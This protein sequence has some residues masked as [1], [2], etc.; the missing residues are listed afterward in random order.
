MQLSSTGRRRVSASDRRQTSGTTGPRVSGTLARGPQRDSGPTVQR[1]T[2]VAKA[3]TGQRSSTTLDSGMESQDVRVDVAA[4]EP[5]K[6][7]SRRVHLTWDNVQYSIPVKV[8]KKTEER[9]LLKGVSGEA[10]PGQLCAI[11]GSSGAGK[12]TLLNVLAGRIDVGNLSGSI[13]VNGDPRTESTWKK[14][15]AFVEQDDL[16]LHNLSVRE[17]LMYAA[18]LRLPSSVSKEDKANRVEKIIEQLGL[19]KCADSWIGSVDTARGISGGERKRVSIGIEL[20]TDPSLLF[21]DEPTSG[22]DAF[23]ACTV[24]DVVKKVAVAGNKTVLCTIHQPR[25]EILELFDSI[26]LLAGGKCI[27]VGSV[28][29][30]V[31]HFASLGIKCPPQT[32]PSDFFL[33]TMTL[34]FR[35]DKLKEESAARIKALQDKWE[36]MPREGGQPALKLEEAPKACETWTAQTDWSNS[37]VVEFLILLDRGFKDLLRNPAN[38]GASMGQATI[39]IIIFGALFWQVTLDSAGVQNRIGFLFMITINQTFG[40]V[41]PIIGVLPVSK[42]LIRRERSAGTYRAGSAFLARVIT[43]GFLPI[44][45]C[46][47]LTAVVYWPIGLRN[48]A[49]QFFIFVGCVSLHSSVSNVLGIMI[50]SIVPNPFVGQIVG[51]LFIMIMLLFGGMLINVS[52]ITP[53]LSWLKYFSTIRYAYSSIS[54]NEF[55]DLKF[56]CPPNGQCFATGDSVLTTYGLEDYSIAW[57]CFASAV[58]GVGFFLIGAFFFA[59]KTK[60]SLRLR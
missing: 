7:P 41:M 6:S 42:A 23:T 19:K 54:Q 52:S 13:L 39:L 21:L 40:V 47:Y 59:V 3:P 32:N 53:A 57:N 11:M 2:V 10:K 37:F 33:D 60:P 44:I 34:D 28:D 26:I 27:F 31:Q 22:L 16:M 5:P 18:M 35:S 48:S 46:V 38:I 50:G 30:G 51:P 9:A 15:V 49:S 29:A 8:G 24:M 45:S 4:V 56:R 43:G 36:S 17:T 55:R 1:G 14:T 12:T 25:S 20:V 58:I